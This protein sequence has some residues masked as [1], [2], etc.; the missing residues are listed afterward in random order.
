MVA[1]PLKTKT[2]NKKTHLLKALHNAFHCFTPLEV[3]LGVGDQSL[4]LNFLSYKDIASTLANLSSE[5]RISQLR[6]THTSLPDE[7]LKLKF[8]NLTLN[9]TP[10]K[11]KLRITEL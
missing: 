4:F 5:P 3:I 9:Y 10:S 7:I 1:R 2:R 11:E 8:P 6:Q